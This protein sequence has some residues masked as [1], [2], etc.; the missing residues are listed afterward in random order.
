MVQQALRE[1]VGELGVKLSNDQVEEI[2]DEDRGSSLRILYQLRRVLSTKAKGSVTVATAQAPAGLQAFAS[3]RFARRDGPQATGGAGRPRLQKQVKTEE[4]APAVRQV[5]ARERFATCPQENFFDQRVKTLR[6]IDQR[7]PYEVHNKAFV[8]E[9]TRQ[10]RSAREKEYEEMVERSANVQ[11]FRVA[12]QR[13]MESSRAQKELARKAGEQHWQGVQEKKYNLLEKDLNFEKEMIRRDQQRIVEIREHY[14]QDCGFREGDEEHGIAWFEKN[15]QRI[16]IDTSE[17]S[18]SDTA[19][20]EAA[21]LKELH[22]KMKE[23]LPSKARLQIESAKRMEK[24]R[25]TKRQTDIARKERERR[26]RRVQYEQ[27]ATTAA[28]EAKKKE[29]DLLTWLLAE[30]AKYRQEAAEYDF[31]LRRKQAQW[32]QREAKQRAYAQRAAVEQDEAWNRMA[33]KAREERQIKQ[34][35]RSNMPDTEGAAEEASSDDDAAPVE[36]GAATTAVEKKRS[37][38]FTS[39]SVSARHSKEQRAAPVVEIAASEEVIACVRETL[40][41]EYLFFR[42]GWAHFKPSEEEALGLLHGALGRLGETSQ[43]ASEPRLGSVV[44]W[45]CKSSTSFKH[46]AAPRTRKAQLASD[47]LPVVALVG[48]PVGLVSGRSTALCN[49]LVDRLSQELGY[50][51]LRSSEVVGECI[52]LSEKPPQEPDWPI[53]ARMRELGKE[54]SQGPRGVSPGVQAEMLFRKIEL[55][56]APAPKPVEEE[57]PKKKPKGKDKKEEVPEPVRP[58][59]ILVLGYPAEL[60]QLASWEAALRGFTSSLLQLMDSEESQQAR[61]GSLLAPFWVEGESATPVV[62]AEERELAKA[63]E[64]ADFDPEFAPPVRIIRLRYP[65]EATLLEAVQKEDMSAE[66]RGNEG[67]SRLCHGLEE[68]MAAMQCAADQ[69]WLFESAQVFATKL[70]APLHNVHDVLVQDGEEGDDIIPAPE[71]ILKRIRELVAFWHRPILEVEAADAD[72]KPDEAVEAPEAEAVVEADA[73]PPEGA[74]GDEPVEPAAPEDGAGD[75]EA[76]QPTEGKDE[77]E[78]LEQEAVNTLL[79]KDSRQT[80]EAFQNLWLQNMSHYL[81]GIRE[82]LLEVDEHASSYCKDLIFMQRRFLEFLQQPDDKAQVLEEFLRGFPVRNNVPPGSRQ[83]DELSEQLQDLAD[84]LWVHANLRKQE[85]VEE[86]YRQ[87][88]GGFWEEKAAAQ[89][90]LAHKL[91]AL[92]LARF[93]VA[94]AVL[95]W[96]YCQVDQ[97]LNCFDTS[98]VEPPPADLSSLQD[99][100]TWLDESAERFGSAEPSGVEEETTQPENELPQADSLPE[101]DSSLLE[102][103]ASQIVEASSETSELVAALKAERHGLVSRCRCI[104][105]W[106]YARLETMHKQHEEVFARMDDWIKDRVKEEN[107]AIKATD[108]LL[109]SGRWEDEEPVFMTTRSMRRSQTTTM[110]PALTGAAGKRRRDVLKVIVAKTL[111]VDVYI[112]QKLEVSEAAV[113]VPTRPS[114]SNSQVAVGSRPSTT[115]P[116]RPVFPE[117]WSQDM[118]WGLLTRLA[119]LSGAVCSAEQLLQALLE[120]R[121]S[122][123]G[124]N[125]EQ[126]IPESWVMRP[127]VV[128]KLLCD[129]MVEPAWGA[130]GVDVTE[131]LLVLSHHENSVPWPTPEALEETRSFIQSEE[132][133]LDPDV[134]S[135]YPDVPISEELFCQL[136]LWPETC[137]PELRRWIFQVLATFAEEQVR[138]PAKPS[139][140]PEDPS[141]FTITAR[142]IFGYFGLGHS[143]A[144]SF[145]RL[146]RLLL[147]R[148][149]LAAEEEPA[150]VLVKDLW[151]LLHSQ[152]SRPSGLL[153]PVPDLATFCNNL[154]E[155]A[156]AETA[157]AAAP[158]G[159]AAPKPKGKA[160]QEVE[161]EVEPPPIPEEATVAFSEKVLL[162]RKTVLRAFCSHGGLLCR[163]RGLEVLF[164]TAG[165][166]WSLATSSQAC[167]AGSFFTS[168]R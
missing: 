80:K 7:Y 43:A 25:D 9:H 40:M 111:D 84:R 31:K 68:E 42:G 129:S 12:Q 41:T 81:L 120:R 20:I 85:A 71:A 10:L 151:M 147:P 88:T 49:S 105:A 125:N 126:V 127:L 99:L 19:T 24:I 4:E 32:E 118:L 55:L 70:S 115:K 77:A 38:R 143:P 94:A 16:G 152:R 155:E 104:A 135:S 97:D 29:E 36:P 146:C 62:K 28:V 108:T 142:R 66:G 107:E 122:A 141:E 54:A 123:L 103:S 23:K 157:A 21:T 73:A 149:A 37:E 131:F 116:L 78:D 6:P 83:A 128:Y 58:K 91:Q 96:T 162:Q 2:M 47:F 53:L 112:P 92:E 113:P 114:T 14:A 159:K 79:I 5:H 76:G 87:M 39:D 136:P 59:G 102:A 161:E 119:D 15:L 64:K 110:K 26:Q 168:S 46:Q 106:T 124:F 61:L 153:A 139:R 67:E 13:K 100:A 8:D 27:A 11:E 34:R 148:E 101:E 109:R 138:L 50:A 48:S 63:A 164:P 156:K 52:A 74:E 30:T 137:P 65:D 93:K 167:H 117:K 95:R 75:K 86:R 69:A 145:S 98:G 3:A 18:G 72:A 134:L 45:L 158:K 121:H 163:R 44:Q 1:A 60:R 57:D 89:L 56:S 90:R 82:T 140:R 17:H 154:L 130:T 22:E 35:Y 165:S 133:P 132:S 33:E 166:G 150:Q 144:E 160:K 51:V